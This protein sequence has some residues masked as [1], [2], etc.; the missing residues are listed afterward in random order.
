V[1]VTFRRGGRSYV[2]PDVAKDAELME[3]VPWLQRKWLAFRPVPHG[4]RLC[5][6]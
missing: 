5:A 1:S 2:V 4:G 6:W 3:P